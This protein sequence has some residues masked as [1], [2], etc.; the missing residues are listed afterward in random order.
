MNSDIT[1]LLLRWREGDESAQEALLPLVYHH[2][3]QLAHAYLARES[4]SPLRDATSIVHE[5]FLRLARSQKVMWKD[6]GHFYG[7]AARTMRQILVEQAR[8]RQA[9][10]RGGG[11][12]RLPLSPELAWVDATSVE[13][14]DLDCALREFGEIFPE[15]LA[16]VEH[17]IFLG[18]SAAE[19]AD[20]LGLSKSTVDRRLNLAK[21]WL[22]DRL[23]GSAPQG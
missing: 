14:V 1:T 17:R 12:Q 10:K 23:K 11:L 13:L 9:S 22:Y 18:C 8:S 5:V 16:V 15:A 19:T 2:L 3:R 7:F 6:R 4:G 20:L 21:A